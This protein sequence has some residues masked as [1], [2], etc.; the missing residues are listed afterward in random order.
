MTCLGV[1]GLRCHWQPSE[2]LDFDAEEL[3]FWLKTIALGGKALKKH[4]PP[5]PKV[6]QWR[7]R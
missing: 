3:E 7:R 6:R 5:K 2:L 4:E 1:L